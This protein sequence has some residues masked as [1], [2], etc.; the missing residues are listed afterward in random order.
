VAPVQDLEPRVDTIAPRQQ[1]AATG[2][3]P[4]EHRPAPRSP[5]LHAE[6]GTLARHLAAAR[7]IQV[8]RSPLLSVDV[9]G[10][11]W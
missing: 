9:R 6:A 5:G 10:M 2:G 7:R 11:G 3:A 1:A 4:R 8:L